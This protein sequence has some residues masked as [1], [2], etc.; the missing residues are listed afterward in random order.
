MKVVNL[1]KAKEKGAIASALTALEKGGLIIYPTETCYGLGADATNPLAIERAL[2]YK[3]ERGHKP[4]S[5][6]VASKAMAEKYVQLNPMAKNLYRHFLP[7]PLTVVSKSKG[8]VVPSL[9]GPHQ[10][11]GI[12]LPGYPLIL[13]LIKAFGKPITSTSANT[14]GKKPPYS[15]QELYQYTSKKR[16][17]MIDLFLDAG[18]LS[19][20]PPSTV[21]DTTLQEPTVLRQ[22]EISLPE[23]GGQV[24]VSHSEDETKTIAQKILTDHQPLITNHSL[25]F[26]L[27]GELGSGKTQFVK[28]LARAL[29]IKTNVPSPTFVLVKEYP[30]HF[31][32]LKRTLYHVDT[33]RMEKGEELLD[34]GLEKMLQPGNIIV[35]E[36]L[37]KVKPVLE[38]LSTKKR[39]KVIWLTIETLSK[40]KRK[41]KY[42]LTK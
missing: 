13:K 34:L 22:G 5:V 29:N 31:K 39:A 12:R 42:R 15:L 10:T 32:K 41:I 36:W 33:W 9:E 16:L 11:L 25:I 38:K 7:G 19:R 8:G 21:V 6:A 24:F 18:R 14:S 23:V 2:E 28:G 3:G 26:A 27:Q 17:A 30:F 4:I 37:Q 20:Q 40:T 35:I 1:E